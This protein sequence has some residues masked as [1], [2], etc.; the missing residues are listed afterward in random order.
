M[1]AS[2]WLER[3]GIEPHVI[4]ASSIP[5]KRE[6]RRAKTDRLDC[7]LLMRAFIGWLRGEVEH[8]RMVAVPSIEAEDAKIP[9]RERGARS[10][11]CTR[12]INRMKATLTCLGIRGFKPELKEAAQRLDDLRLPT[13]EALP[14]NALAELRRDMATLR[15]LK[16][17]IKEIKEARET[18]LEEAPDEAPH[19]MVRLLATVRGLGM[20]TA[21]ML[22]SEALSRDLPDRRAVARYG[23]LTG[24]PDE[25]GAKRRERGLARAGNA[26]VR[27]GMIQLAW[28]FLWYQPDCALVKWY[29]ARAGADRNARKKL[30]VALARKLLIA[31][32]RFVTQGLVPEGVVFNHAR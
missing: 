21:D 13:G 14:P 31:L 15:L 29:Q 3:H 25:S 20:E 27:H 22:V 9:H 19:T 4:H 11:D 16:D 30:I 12:A 32:W 18:H 10:R 26:R 28:R 17:Q 2:G 1:A 23:G 24:S 6:Q 5:V 8:C 7:R